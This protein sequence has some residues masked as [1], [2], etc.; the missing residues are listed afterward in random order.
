MKRSILENI[1]K[2]LYFKPLLVYWVS[3]VIEYGFLDF[4][5][6]VESKKNVI[7]ERIK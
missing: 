6:F 5:F 4:S 3:C 1:E 2:C 7:K